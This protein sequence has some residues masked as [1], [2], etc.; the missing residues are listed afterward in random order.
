MSGNP[1]DLQ[2]ASGAKPA[3]MPTSKRRLLPSQGEIDR[4]WRL[5]ADVI[6]CAN[7]FH[8]LLDCDN[9]ILA[10]NVDYIMFSW[11]GSQI[12]VMLW[13]RSQHTMRSFTPLWELVGGSVR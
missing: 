1:S 13:H 5:G 9:S 6:D 3:L 8:S 12:T 4:M 10:G 11:L 2:I 7:V